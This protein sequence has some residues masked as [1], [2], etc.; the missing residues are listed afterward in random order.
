MKVWLGDGMDHYYI[1]SRFLISRV[2]TVTKI[3]YMKVMPSYRQAA[4]VIRVCNK[5]MSLQAVK[6]SLE[7]KKLL[8][9]SNRFEV[10]QVTTPQFGIAEHLPA[11]QCFAFPFDVYRLTLRTHSLK[12]W[13]AG[14]LVQNISSA[15]RW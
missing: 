6:I 2:L 14:A 8:V 3:P 13:R 1:L 15:T 12:S 10:S 9:D 11:T 4:P 7:V 5:S